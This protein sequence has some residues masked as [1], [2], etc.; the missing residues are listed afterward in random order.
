MYR[1]K[2]N[3]R[4]E[5]FLVLLCVPA[6][7]IFSDAF[8]FAGEQMSTTLAKGKERTLLRGNAEIQSDATRITAGE[9]EIY[10]KDFQFAQ[11]R[12]GVTA[13]DSE[14]EIL[15][16]CETLTYDRFEKI[17]VASGKAYMEDRKNEIIVQ[18]QRLENRDK[19][20]LTIVQVGVRILKKDLSA[21][22][23]YVRY[24]RDTDM[25][26]LSGLPQ[27]FWKKDEYKAAK[28]IMNLKTEEITLVGDVSGAIVS[29]S[30]EEPETE[31]HGE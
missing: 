20:D 22:A 14:T 28:I 30:K 16:T 23:E 4:V 11:C 27:V 13:W 1:K 15:I 9:I 7:G 8:R 26:E 12:G 19:E 21:R 5:W 2:S 6:L 25:L 18:G 31:N 3:Y 17:I 24:K 10:G 29:E